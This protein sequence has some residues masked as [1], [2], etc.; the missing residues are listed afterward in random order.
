MSSMITGT[1]GR[2]AAAR[3]E[4]AKTASRA[5]TLEKFCPSLEDEATNS[6]RPQQASDVALQGCLPQSLMHLRLA[7]QHRTREGTPEVRF[8][9]RAINAAPLPKRRPVSSAALRTP[10]RSEPTAAEPTFGDR[11]LTTKVLQEKAFGAIVGCGQPSREG[12]AH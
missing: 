3:R 9:E 5:C 10:F 11:P 8:H 12:V 2:R 1:L 6:A 7:P 4:R